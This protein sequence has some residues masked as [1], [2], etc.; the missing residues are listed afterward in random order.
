MSSRNDA[1]VEAVQSPGDPEPEGPIRSCGEVDGGRDGRRHGAE[2]AIATAP[3]RTE[4]VE[5]ALTAAKGGVSRLSPD[6]SGAATSLEVLLLPRP[7]EVERH[8]G[9]GLEAGG[10]AKKRTRRDREDGRPRDLDFP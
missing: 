2:G 8:P 10:S 7:G 9:G 5:G 3:S 1:S 4:D 6:L